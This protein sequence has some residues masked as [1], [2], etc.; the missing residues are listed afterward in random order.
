MTSNEQTKPA[1][2]ASEK[3]SGTPKTNKDGLL[4]GQE[5]SFEDLQRI[6][7]KQH[8]EQATKGAQ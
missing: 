6:K 1:V 2:T 4:P 7:R 5:V 8:Q 3:I